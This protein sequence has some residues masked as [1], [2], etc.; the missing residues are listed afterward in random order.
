[1]PANTRL[2][3]ARMA[4]DVAAL[5]SV[6]RRSA[7]SRT[8]PER[9]RPSS[10][11]LGCLPDPRLPQDLRP[12]PRRARRDDL[13]VSDGRRGAASRRTGSPSKSR[14]PTAPTA[15]SIRSRTASR[16]SAPGRSSRTAPT[17]CKDPTHWQERT[18]DI[19]DSLSDALHECLTQRFVDR[20]T[21]ALMKGM[22][23]KDELTRRD[24]R[25]RRHPRREPFRRTPEGL[26][27]LAR[28]RTAEGIHGK[29]TR[30]AAAQVLSREL[31]MRARRVAAAKADAFKLTRTRPHPVARRGDRQARSRRRSAEAGVYAACRRAPAGAD[32]EKVQARARHLA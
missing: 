14:S 7:R 13:Q 23:D 1:M 28:S 16:T 12:E 31:G 30:H 17:G 29:A 15:I 9:P 4:D 3:R 22:R 6:E 8:S 24:R 27:L 32:R 11:A 21:S 19:E 10:T 25:R 18:R 5:E 2:A 26:P 20:R